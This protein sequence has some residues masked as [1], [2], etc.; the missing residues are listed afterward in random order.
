MLAILERIDAQSD[1]I[2]LLVELCGALRPKH[3]SDAALATAKVRTL[4]QLLKGNPQQA[5]ALR[6]TILRVLASRRHT[7]LYTDIGILSND[8]FVTELLRRISYRILPPG[9]TG[10]MNAAL[11]LISAPKRRPVG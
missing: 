1:S 8:G 6:N 11:P 9:N 3:P 4:C 5:R 2:D 10:Q 7:S